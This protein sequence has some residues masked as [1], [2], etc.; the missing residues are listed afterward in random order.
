MNSRSG[1]HPLSIQYFVYYILVGIFLPYFNLYCHH[2]GFTGMEIGLLSAVR[3]ITLVVFAMF[4]GSLADRYGLRRPIYIACAFVS[5]GIWGLYFHARQFW[6]MLILTAGYGLFFAPLISFLEAAT[7]EALGEKKECY[8]KVRVWGTLSFIL[9]VMV[10]GKLIALSSVD[11]VLPGVLVCSIFLCFFARGF[12][13]QRF[14][15]RGARFSTQRKFLMSRRVLCFLFCVFLMLVSHGAYYGFFSIY[16]EGL[17]YGSVFIGFAWALAAAAEVALMLNS[18]AVFKRFSL[19]AV[20]QASFL[21]A[22]L[23][24]GMLAMAPQTTVILISQLLHAATYGSFHIASLLYMDRLAPQEN[25]T[26][27]QASN[28]AVTYGLGLM[29]GYLLS[30]PLYE[31]WGGGDAVSGK[32]FACWSHVSGVPLDPGEREIGA[33]GRSMLKEDTA[34]E[35]TFLHPNRL[36]HSLLRWYHAHRRDLPWRKTSDPYRIL[37]SEVMLQQTQ[38]KT[39]VPYYERFID[40][41]PTAGALARAEL[42]EVLKLWEGLGY[43]AR[44]RNLHRAAG[45]AGNVHGGEIPMDSNAIRKLPG[46]GDY[47]AAAVLSIAFGLPFAVVDGNVKRVI[48]RLRCMAHP[49]NGAP[50]PFQASADALL[51]RTNPG[52]FNQAMMELGALICKP[53]N[54]DCG[55]CPV[56][57][58]CCA[59]LAGTVLLYPKREERKKVPTHHV[60]VGVVWRGEKVLITKRKEDGLLGGLWEFPGGKVQFGESPEEACVREIREETALA[61]AVTGHIAQVKHAYTHFKIVMDV[62]ACRALSGR[63]RLSG[64]TDHRWI[65]LSEIADYPFPK[66]NHKFFKALIG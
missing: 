14:R 6:P 38:V 60:A 48:S 20:L 58:D 62:Y 12:P 45:V 25:K 11:M 42:Q 3:S 33:E 44:A 63:V 52:D 40:R 56:R 32:Q 19:E 65:A 22:M 55:A 53:D 39:V 50:A 34:G 23:R 61:V 47:I 28:N 29:V 17:G 21:A 59:F 26:L 1:T 24:W 13:V 10:T 57:K 31:R 2:L 43:Y 4:W 30:G 37:V 8:G 36:Q 46:V 51:D 64:A 15:E 9:A 27:G 5:T 41:F 54:P 35:Q 7:M 66:A 18:E 49:V 16:L